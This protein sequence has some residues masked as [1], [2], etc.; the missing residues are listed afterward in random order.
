M[1]LEPDMKFGHEYL[2]AAS[3]L[4]EIRQPK[5][6]PARADHPAMRLSA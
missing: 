2:R 3:V 4:D 5:V 6:L 1:Y